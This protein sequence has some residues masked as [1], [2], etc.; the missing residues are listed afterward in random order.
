MCEDLKAA[1]QAELFSNHESRGL[2]LFWRAQ[3]FKLRRRRQQAQSAAHR[4]RQRIGGGHFGDCPHCG[5]SLRHRLPELTPHLKNL[6][7]G[8]NHARN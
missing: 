6:Y 4:G 8:E 5:G 3:G 7:D 1:A 2:G